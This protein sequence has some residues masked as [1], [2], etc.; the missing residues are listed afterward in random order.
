[1]RLIT[2]IPRRRG[3]SGWAHVARRKGGGGG[4]GGCGPG[5]RTAW[6]RA[7]PGAPEH[8]GIAS[9]TAGAN[10]N[11]QL[12]TR[13]LSKGHCAGRSELGT[14]SDLHCQ[15]VRR[16]RRCIS[17][18]NA[19]ITELALATGGREAAGWRKKQE[20]RSPPRPRTPPPRLT[21]QA[22][23]PLRCSGF[24]AVCCVSGGAACCCPACRLPCLLLSAL[25]GSAQAA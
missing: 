21:A 3:G 18:V 17:S 6:G 25:Q 16:T 10:S 15:M 4:M 20:A 8:T 24:A 11:H 1:M 23:A 9:P 12:R 2:E 13:M 22:A 14:R 5:T 19:N 7:L